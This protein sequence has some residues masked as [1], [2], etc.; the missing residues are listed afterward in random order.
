M[1]KVIEHKW[2]AKLDSGQEANVTEGFVSANFGERFKNELK[3]LG[4]N[5]YVPIPP[6]RTRTSVLPWAPN[7]LHAGA[8]KMKYQQGDHDTCVFSSLASALFHTGITSL[9]EIAHEL[10]RKS[11]KLS[12]GV[13]SL[14]LVKKLLEER[15]S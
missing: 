12:G 10:H 9:K 4:D 13:H 15:A 5:S 11:K 6:G 14:H 1:I 8:P 3:R 2:K 7:L